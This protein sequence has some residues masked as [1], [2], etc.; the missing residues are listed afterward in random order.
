MSALPPRADIRPRKNDVCK[1]PRAVT[2]ERCGR[3]GRYRLQSLIAERG[4]DASVP[5]WLHELTAACEI[6]QAQNWGDQCVARCP[7]LPKM[8]QLVSRRRSKSIANFVT[9]ITA[10]RPT[11]PC[12][13]RRIR[14]NGGTKPATAL[15]NRPT[16]FSA[17]PRRGGL[18]GSA[19]PN[20][21][22]PPSQAN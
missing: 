8:L 15:T 5:D 21:H 16:S 19:R 14:R 4:P 2:C 20:G 9:A 18:A 11:L 17:S 22:R 10:A 1:G 7:D 12:I 3:K 6:K 13:I